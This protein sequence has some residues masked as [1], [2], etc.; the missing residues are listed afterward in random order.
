MVKLPPPN[1]LLKASDR[2]NMLRRKLIL[3][4]AFCTL[5]MNCF[6]LLFVMKSSV[7]CGFLADFS[8]VTGCSASFQVCFSESFDE[9]QT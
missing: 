2:K 1:A 5:H 6:Y 9:K 7:G 3:F 8:K 4:H